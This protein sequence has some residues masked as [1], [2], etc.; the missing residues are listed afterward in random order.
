MGKALLI[1]LVGFSVSF[2][3][4]ARNKSRRYVDSVDRAVN[5]FSGYSAENAATG[6]VYMALNR[7]YRN[8]TWR[9]GYPKLVLGG[10]TI[11]VALD[12]WNTDSTLAAKRI[13]VRSTARNKNL[14]EVSQ[15]LLFDG[16]F[17]KYAI[18]AKDTV[19]NVVTVN[20]VDVQDMALLMHEAPF[21]PNFKKSEM[22][23]VAQSQSHVQAGPEWTPANQYPNN[24]FYSS[25]SIP[26]VTHVQGNLKVLENHTIYGIFIVDGDV[27]IQGNGLVQGILYLPNA[28]AAIRS[29]G[30][31]F[32]SMAKVQGGI[33]TWGEIDGTNRVIS[34]RMQSTYMAAFKDNYA[35]NNPPLRVLSW[36]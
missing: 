22:L 14:V 33:V 21:M 36:K 6:G 11:T 16:N 26:N 9:T 34:V 19:L 31:P 24:S 4:L 20:T 8:N 28:D 7:L 17:N 18:W 29:E 15:A 1:L 13:R 3:L 23:G 5:K 2:G 25:G 12:D 10:D 27:I 30:G 32:G 35:P